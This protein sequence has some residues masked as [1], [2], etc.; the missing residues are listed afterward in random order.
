MDYIALQRYLRL[1]L[2][3]H[4]GHS[5]MILCLSADDFNRHSKSSVW[6]IP[7]LGTLG[8]TAKAG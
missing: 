8:W 3:H 4:I 7:L 5:V 6:F 1:L 2:D